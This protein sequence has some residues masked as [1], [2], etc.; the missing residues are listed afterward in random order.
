VTTQLSAAAGA[1]LFWL[2]QEL[3]LYDGCNLERRLDIELAPD[4]RLLMVE[5]VLFGRRAMGEVLRSARFNDRIAIRRAGRPAYID[6][7]D[8]SGDVAATLDR[9]AVGAGAVA[10]AS[11]VHVAP[12]AEAH[13]SALRAL[14]PASGGAT[15]LAP[16]MLALRLV[17]EDGH[18]LR[19]ALLPVLDRLTSD[20]LPISWR[21]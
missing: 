8:L 5:P 16:D 15:L 19:Q 14:M 20:S 3:I 9:A 2:P 6:G 12:D 13:L 17:A 11:L 1:T 10:M 18:A 21:L 7:V 4:A